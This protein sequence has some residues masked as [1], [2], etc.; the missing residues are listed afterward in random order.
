MLLCALHDTAIIT[1]AR[2]K[3]IRFIPLLWADI[4]PMLFIGV[5]HRYRRD[6]KMQV[7]SLFGFGNLEIPYVFPIFQIP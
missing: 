7:S 5:A 2:V 6:S 1:I 4:V 3:I